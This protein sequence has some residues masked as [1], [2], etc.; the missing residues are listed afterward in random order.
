MPHGFNES[1]SK[2]QTQEDSMTDDQMLDRSK[3]LHEALRLTIES[4]TED[5]VD[6]ATDAEMF[7]LV[8]SVLTQI[9]VSCAQSAGMDHDQFVHRMRDSYTF[10]TSLDTMAQ[11]LDKAAGKGGDGD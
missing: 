6:E 3:Q 5:Y 7:A 2:Q 1:T 10:L 4:M 9:I 11:A 8:M